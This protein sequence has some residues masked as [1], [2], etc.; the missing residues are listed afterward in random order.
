VTIN[1][2]IHSLNQEASISRYTLPIDITIKDLTSSIEK[3][4][5]SNF[6]VFAKG[7]QVDKKEKIC[8]VGLEEGEKLLLWANLAPSKP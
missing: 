5:S 6:S 7:K 3:L 4:T 8:D 1:I 2:K